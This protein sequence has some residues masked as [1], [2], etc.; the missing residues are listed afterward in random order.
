MSVDFLKPDMI[1]MPEKKLPKLNPK[2]DAQLRK[3]A[4]EFE[5]LFMNMVVQKMRESVPD[6]GLFDESGSQKV[7]FFE[8]MLDE[9]YS[10]IS[11]SKSNGGIGDLIYKQLSRQMAK[12]GGAQDEN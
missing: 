2:D 3:A 11:A 9:E 10:K 12:S 4:K 1:S 6:S 8:A 7:K 5:S